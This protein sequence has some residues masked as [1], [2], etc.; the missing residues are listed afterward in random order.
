MVDWQQE[1]CYWDLTHPVWTAEGDQLQDPALSFKKKADG[2]RN[3][4][5]WGSGMFQAAARAA[6]T[7]AWLLRTPY[8]MTS[9]TVEHHNRKDVPARSHSHRRSSGFSSSSSG[10]FSSGSSFG[11][12][13]FSVLEVSKSS[14]WVAAMAVAANPSSAAAMAAAAPHPVAD[15]PTETATAFS[16]GTSAA[17]QAS[18]LPSSSSDQMQDVVIM[19]LSDL[20]A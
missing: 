13:S 19:D 5:S 12:N 9:M 10:S 18:V 14:P 16:G 3:W 20:M 7:D 15:A 1:M 2:T 17:G 8:C 11:N 6:H 4:T